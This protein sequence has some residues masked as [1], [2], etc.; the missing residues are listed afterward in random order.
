M[1]SW[2]KRKAVLIPYH[3]DNQSKIFKD[4]CYLQKIYEKKLTN[5]S[6]YFNKIHNENMSKRAWRIIIGI[7]LGYFIQI[8]YDRYFMIKKAAKEFKLHPVSILS[9]KQGELVP[10]DMNEFS[11]LYTTDD[12]NEK[13]YAE[14]IY[15]LK[16][17]FKIIKN[18]KQKTI[19]KPHAPFKKINKL[20]YRIFCKKT[21][22]FLISTYLKPLQEAFLQISL[23][24]FPIKWR[25]TFL[26]NIPYKQQWRNW[27]F[28]KNYPKLKNKSE[29]ENL[30]DFLIPKNI[31]KY[32]LEGYKHLGKLVLALNWPNKPKLI[33]TSNS[34][35][36]DD[37]FKFW[38][39]KQVMKKTPLVIGQHGGNFG[40]A[41]WAFTEDHQ[42]LISDQFVS[43]GWKRKEFNNIFP[44]GAFPFFGSR[45]LKI[46]ENG[47]IVLIQ[48]KFVHY[49]Y[50]MAS[51][52]VATGQYLEYL[53][54]QKKLIE[55]LPPIIKKNL[56]I[57]LT[58]FKD[59]N[60]YKYWKDGFPEI[61]IDCG[62]KPFRRVLKGACLSISTYNAT[63]FLETLA[64]NFPTLIFWDTKRTEIRKEAKPL[65]KILETAGIFHKT[66]ESI[67]KKISEIYGQVNFWW[68]KQEIQKARK[69]F[70]YMYARTPPRARLLLKQNF[71][72]LANNK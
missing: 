9:R 29:F 62:L 69:E 53:N 2:K 15:F 57:R 33:F 25:S 71:Q 7:W 50:Q 70:C 3:W 38:A 5:L 52:P 46:K 47:K 42:I 45:T 43:W 63:S 4:Y 37:L 65:F 59:D 16:I 49:S 12:W 35:S 10:N 48:R 14:I 31:P 26:K 66:P 8:S 24:Q 27:R 39:A 28:D 20:F 1:E 32:Y 64:I 68:K 67:A 17:P 58:Y 18:I 21:P 11:N 40:I 23:G 44:F 34:Y 6:L 61:Q 54:N 60:L 22:Y 30:L 72:D 13:I 51:S 55:K 56:L 41:K 36:F 19:Q